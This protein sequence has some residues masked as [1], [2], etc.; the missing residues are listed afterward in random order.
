[1]LIKKMD[2]LCAYRVLIV[3][4]MIIHF[5]YL[6]QLKDFHVINVWPNSHVYQRRYKWKKKK[7]T[8]IQKVLS[9]FVLIY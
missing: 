9:F 6:I 7:K 3:H 1:M 5:Y 2:E 8:L 4:D